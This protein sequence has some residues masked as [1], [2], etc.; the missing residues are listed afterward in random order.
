[1]KSDSSA[2]CNWT[3]FIHPLDVLLI[4]SFIIL[5]K[6]FFYMKCIFTLSCSIIF[7][8]FLKTSS[9]TF[10]FENFELIALCV[11]TSHFLGF[12]PVVYLG[13]SWRRL[14]YQFGPRA[15]PRHLE[16]PLPLTCPWLA[17]PHGTPHSPKLPQR[18]SLRCWWDGEPTWAVQMTEPSEVFYRDF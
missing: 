3:T 11:Y 13:R 12:Y 17:C 4:V 10:L 15:G 1:M 18:H 14:D 6:Y 2:S 8:I 9:I 16:M 7:I 5:L